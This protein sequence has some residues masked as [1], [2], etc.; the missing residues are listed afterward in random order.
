MSMTGIAG[1]FMV[2]KFSATGAIS[3]GQIFSLDL[4]CKVDGWM[5]LLVADINTNHAGSLTIN[6]FG[7][8]KD[9]SVFVSI[10]EPTNTWNSAT[11][12]CT[13]LYAKAGTLASEERLY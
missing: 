12:N 8:R 11:I 1:P 3:K 9:G 7:I 6:Q 2:K 5:P 4:D 10:F 13:V